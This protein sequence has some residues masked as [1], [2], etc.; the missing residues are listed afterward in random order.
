MT[1][2]ISVDGRLDKQGDGNEDESLGSGDIVRITRMKCMVENFGE[3][4][5]GAAEAKI[6]NCE[7]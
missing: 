7:I 1:D 5:I 4:L 3:I 2:E 6:E